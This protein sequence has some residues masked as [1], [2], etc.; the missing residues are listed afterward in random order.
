[1]KYENQFCFYI[2]ILACV[3]VTCYCSL[4][5]T[6][7]IYVSFG[8]NAARQ[9]LVVSAPCYGNVQSLSGYYMTVITHI[10]KSDVHLCTIRDNQIAIHLH[11]KKLSND[12]L[13][14]R[15]LAQIFSTPIQ[16]MYLLASCAENSWSP[17]D[18]QQQTAKYL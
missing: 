8:T 1:M 15:V 17:L 12:S 10:C 13:V 2:I 3:C 9:H 14:Q 18:H 11:S 16:C 4:C 5:S 6:V 7:I